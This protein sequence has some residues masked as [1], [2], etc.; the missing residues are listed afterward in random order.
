MLKKGEGG[1]GDYTAKTEKMQNYFFKKHYIF[2]IIL[3]INEEREIARRQKIV[4]WS[5]VQALTSYAE[6]NLQPK[7]GNKSTSLSYQ[8]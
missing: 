3:H 2:L 6:I 7:A 8:F 5:N 4:C 1:R